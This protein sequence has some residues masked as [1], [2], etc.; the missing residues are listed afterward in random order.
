VFRLRTRKPHDEN[1]QWGFNPAYNV[2]FATDTGSGIIVG[3]D[4]NNEGSDAGLAVP[5]IETDPATTRHNSRQLLLDGGFAMIKDT[6]I[7]TQMESC[8]YAGERRREET[9]QGDRPVCSDS[10]DAPEIAAWRQT[11]GT[12]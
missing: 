2:Q 12:D 4:V 6:I 11:H 7:L 9:C 5:M 10:Q 1:G 8:L 3:V